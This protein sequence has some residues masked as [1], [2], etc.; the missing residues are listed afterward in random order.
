MHADMPAIL[1]AEDNP[2]HAQLVV[3][4]LRKH[5]GEDAQ[6]RL[7]DDGQTA[8]DYLF[9][10]GEYQD[11]S[12]SP[13]PR[14]V[15]LDLRLPKRDGL[16]VLRAVKNNETLAEIP[17]VILTS[18]DAPRDIAEAYE[19]HVNSYLVK[20]V[21]FEQFNRMIKNLCVYWLQWNYGNSTNRSPLSH[22]THDPDQ[23]T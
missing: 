5:C 9:R 6:I 21:A 2:D 19:S 4:C 17:I 20:P 11:P 7:V 22:L 16:E 12:T 1:Y 18:S 23:N 14:V 15:L 13:R 10:R 8:L 3:R